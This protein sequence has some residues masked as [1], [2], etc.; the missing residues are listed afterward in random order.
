MVSLNLFALVFT[1]QEPVMSAHLGW[2][3]ALEVF[4]TAML[5]IELMLRVVVEGRC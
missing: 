1:I 5:V 4:I 2:F 3:I